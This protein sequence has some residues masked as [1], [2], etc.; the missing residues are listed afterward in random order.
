[1]NFLKNGTKLSIFDPWKCNVEDFFLEQSLLRRCHRVAILKNL[2]DRIL[3]K[4]HTGH[5][6]IVKM[7]NL[8]RGY[9]WWPDISYDIE[10]L[11]NDIFF[12]FLSIAYSGQ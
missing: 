9:C 2:H 3:S 8:A 11:S 10:H 5:F 12:Y 7:K 1:M 4:L 6:G